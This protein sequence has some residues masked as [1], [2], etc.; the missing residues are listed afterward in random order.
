MR[1]LSYLVTFSIIALVAVV[2]VAGAQGSE[3]T[4][5]AQEAT[6]Q[7]I[8]PNNFV[9]EVDNKYFPLKP[10]TRFS[11]KGKEG[12]KGTKH[13]VHISDEVFVTHDTKQIQGVTTTVVRDRAFRRGVLVED[14]FDWYAQD[15]AGNVWYFGEDTKE[16]DKNGNV[17]STEGSWEAGKNGAK[18]GIIMEANPKVGDTYQQEFAPGVAEDMAKVLK[19]NASACVPYRCFDNLLLTREW[20][21]L[22]PGVVDHKY[23][24]PG[25]GEIKEETAKGG[26][27][28]LVLVNI[29]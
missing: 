28:T 11:Y 23:Y 5:S 27:E 15:R 12:K 20:T 26:L 8:D 13:G 10:G 4:V 24:A 17:I 19:L 18:P 1:Q 2:T 21:P 25:V 6:S 29:S 7:D 14:T 9:S 3:Q 16:L 22:E